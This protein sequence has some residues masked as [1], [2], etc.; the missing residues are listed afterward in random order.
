MRPRQWV[1]NV[2]VAAVPAAA[3]EIG[4][5]EVLAQTA[6]AFVAFCLAS[7]A[8]YLV[9][10]LA[11]RTADRAH[12]VK[13]KR[14]I[15]SGALS[16][17]TAVVAAVVAAVAAI[18][19][20]AVASLPLAGGVAGYLALTAA[21]TGGLKHEP[22]FD[23]ATVAAGFFLRAVA[24]GLA[25]G[26]D[27]SR[28]FLIVAA[29]ASLFVVAGKRYAE[30]VRATAAG[31]PSRRVLAHYSPGYLQSVFTIAAAVTVVAYCLWAFEDSGD[32]ATG[33]RAAS[34]A[35]FVLAIMRYGLLLDQGHGEEP[36]ELLLGDRVLVGV[37][38]CWVALLMAG[39][40]L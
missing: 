17:R 19:L 22:V 12:P 7:S 28:W 3:G 36:E 6:L 10:D 1:K 31:T 26:L 20:A 39:V 8:T 34:V 27:V 23:I 9:N 16:A 21:Y 11:D 15:A 40:L 24:G 25:T 4:D 38:V 32:V 14:P 18:A 2:L 30:S 5:L 29:G 37:G 33:W 35:P 13:H